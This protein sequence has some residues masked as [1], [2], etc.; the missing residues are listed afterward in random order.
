M[1]II[2]I[3]LDGPISPIGFYN[4]SIRLPWPLFF[5]L[6]P[7]IIFLKPDPQVVKKMQVLKDQG[8]ILAIVSATPKQFRWF[9][10]LLLKLHH[11]PFDSLDCVDGGKGTKERKL[12]VIKEKK[13]EV[14][15]DDDIRIL[16]FLQ[17]NSVKAV[18]SLDQLN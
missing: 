18:S 10:R 15:I 7:I 12:K 11:I 9:R 17:S 1:K 5:L 3:D 16:N 2:G 14:F 6:V 8:C 13:I 4:P